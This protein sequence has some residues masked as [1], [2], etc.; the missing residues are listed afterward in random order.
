[1]LT[2]GETRSALSWGQGLGAEVKNIGADP[3][4]LSQ[5]KTRRLASYG[6]VNVAPNWDFAP[7]LL[8]QHSADRYRGR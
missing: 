3:A 6:M 5:A 7:S 8:A 1:M 2:A 4:L